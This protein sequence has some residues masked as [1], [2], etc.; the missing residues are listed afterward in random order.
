VEDISQWNGEG[1]VTL[2]AF[3]AEGRKMSCRNVPDLPCVTVMECDGARVRPFKAPADHEPV[4]PPFAD[5]VIA[6]AGADCFGK[7][8]GEI[9]HRPERVAALLGTDLDHLITPA[10]VARVLAS[11]AGGRKSVPAG[12]AFRCAVNKA[13]GGERRELALRCAEELRCLGVAAAVTSFTEEERGGLCC[14]DQGPG[15]GLRIAVRLRRAGIR[16]S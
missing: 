7:S 6:V 13:D 3:N 15:P 9:C 12:A 2:G 5:A 16:S 8:I 1:I 10:D 4:I 11:P 14:F